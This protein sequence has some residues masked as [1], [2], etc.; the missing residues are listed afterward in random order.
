MAE[1]ALPKRI[2]RW[3]AAWESSDVER[4]LA[5]Y[6]AKCRHESALVPRLYPEAKGAILVGPKALRAYLERGVAWF[7]R[8]RFE[9]VSIVE[10]ER[11]SAIEYRRHSDVDGGS[12]AH[13]LE[14][15]EWSGDEIR[16]A[17]VFQV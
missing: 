12:P 4:I 1:I 7:T 14:L 13:V 15:L 5:L 11:R 3:K 10:D 9:V 6:A 16:S 8:V 2:E 17:V